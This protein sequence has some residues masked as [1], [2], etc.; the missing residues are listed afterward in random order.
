[1]ETNDGASKKQQLC[2]NFANDMS[3]AAPRLSTPAGGHDS[4]CVAGGSSAFSSVK[5]KTN[6]E[7]EL[8]WIANFEREVYEGNQDE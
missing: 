4:L 7:V 5:Q 2:H 3:R 8:C 1:L 6:D